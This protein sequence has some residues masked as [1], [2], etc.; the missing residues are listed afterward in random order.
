MGVK[1]IFPYFYPLKA[2]FWPRE[3]RRKW[4]RKRYTMA[5]V[6]VNCKSKKSSKLLPKT[7][8]AKISI[9]LVK[10]KSRKNC[11]IIYTVIN[12]VIKTTMHII[13][14]HPDWVNF[15]T[16]FRFFHQKIE[17]QRQDVEKPRQ[18]QTTAWKTR[19]PKN[20]ATCFF[21]K[22]PSLKALSVS[23]WVIFP[24][25]I[26]RLMSWDFYSHHWA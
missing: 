7:S 16:W 5:P 14:C 19:V 10:C 1:I 2:N 17:Q 8:N 26:F 13:L 9:C 3:I 24:F 21:R 25:R 4:D 22:A 12:P 6:I 23:F 11:N 18:G 20:F 15:K